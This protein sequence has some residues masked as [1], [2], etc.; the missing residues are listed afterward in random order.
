VRFHCYGC[1]KS[2]S[3]EL[4]AGAV[5]RAIAICPECLVKAGVVTFR[6]PG[7]REATARKAEDEGGDVADE[8]LPR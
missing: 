7:R 6:E 1:G 4:E 8:T 2:V 5:L 3:S